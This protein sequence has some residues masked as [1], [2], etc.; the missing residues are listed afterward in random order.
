M[1]AIEEAQKKF[2][3]RAKIIQSTKESYI[4]LLDQYTRVLE[5]FLVAVKNWAK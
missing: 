3:E 5:E 1:D 4:R 2:E